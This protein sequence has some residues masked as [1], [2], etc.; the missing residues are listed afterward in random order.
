MESMNIKFI[1]KAA[2]ITAL[3][4][5]MTEG[6]LYVKDHKLSFHR[7][8]ETKDVGNEKKEEKDILN[9]E[10]HL[11]DLGWLIA[12]GIDGAEISYAVFPGMTAPDLSDDEWKRNGQPLLPTDTLRPKRNCVVAIRGE[13]EGNKMTQ[14]IPFDFC[15]FVETIIDT[16]DGDNGIKEQLFLAFTD[17]LPLLIN[18]D[19]NDICVEDLCKSECDRG[20]LDNFYMA[21]HD[22]EDSFQVDS[23]L[24]YSAAT[25]TDEALQK[26]YPPIAFI[27]VRRT[28]A[29]HTPNSDAITAN[30]KPTPPMPAPNSEGYV[31]WTDL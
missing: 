21:F 12:N 22:E 14:V 15:R 25:P 30:T 26:Y 8:E 13:K 17:E 11:A 4:A 7:D 29:S 2:A 31:D 23:I 18:Y 24:T 5:L 9:V 16:N 28:T 19:Y 1:L 3:A 10:D 27:N 20:K 6:A